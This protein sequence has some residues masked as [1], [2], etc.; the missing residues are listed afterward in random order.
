MVSKFKIGNRTIGDNEP[1][2]I[3]AEIG[4]NHN[5][6]LDTAI[7]I[8]ESAVKSGAEVIKHQTHI[9]DDE[10][11]NEAKKIIPGNSSKSIYEIISQSPTNLLLLCPDSW[12]TYIS[13]ISLT[14]TTSHKRHHG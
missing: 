8:A 5:G 2:L 1:P 13:H 7:A 11:I 9:V 4:I 3:I 10:M 14:K 6:S 12:G